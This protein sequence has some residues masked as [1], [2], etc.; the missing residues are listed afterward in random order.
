MSCN[1]LHDPFDPRIVFAGPRV[2]PI[3]YLS[4]DLSQFTEVDEEDYG[5]LVRHLWSIHYDQRGKAYVRRLRYRCPI[6]LH[7]V[8]LERMGPP[9]SPLHT[10]CDHINGD[11][12]DNRRRN[13]R[14]ATPSENAKNIH[15]FGGLQAHFWRRQA[16]QEAVD[17]K[18]EV[19]HNG[20][21]PSRGNY[22]WKDYRSSA[23]GLL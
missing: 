2:Q 21:L 6:Y 1:R 13:L 15:Y 16:E 4:R 12:L 7:R 3:I 5:F 11:G 22:R 10:V 14:W 8:I 19:W 23:Q 17:K 20:M 9:P 18:S